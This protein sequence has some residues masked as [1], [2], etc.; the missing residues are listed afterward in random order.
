MV[1]C[2]L[3][4][5]N[6]RGLEFDV[7]R[8]LQ[9]DFGDKIDYT[10][11]N[12][13]FYKIADLEKDG[14]VHPD[15]MLHFQFAVKKNNYMQRLELAKEQNREQAKKAIEPY[16]DRIERLNEDLWQKITEIVLCKK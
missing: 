3:T 15:G 10:V 4:L 13:Q 2:Q 12:E 7:N 6:I 8:V 5:M 11:V 16:Q 1:T 9:C 14:F